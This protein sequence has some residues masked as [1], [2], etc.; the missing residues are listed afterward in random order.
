MRVW[1]FVFFRG[2]GPLYL[3]TWNI[4]GCLWLL[5]KMSKLSNESTYE[6]DLTGSCEINMLHTD[7]SLF[8][9]GILNAFP[10]SGDDHAGLASVN[11]DAM[12]YELE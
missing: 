2:R 9:P 7:T 11:I 1:A 5:K 10:D 6:R 3:S 8:P 12:F 4:T